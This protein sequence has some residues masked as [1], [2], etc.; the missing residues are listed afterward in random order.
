MKKERRRKEKTFIRLHSI[1]RRQSVCCCSGFLSLFLIYFKLS[2]IGCTR[3]EI[4]FPSASQIINPQESESPC[5]IMITRAPDHGC[6]RE[7]G[8][9]LVHALERLPFTRRERKRDPAIMLSCR[10]HLEW[11]Y[12]ETNEAAM[13][14]SVW[15]AVWTPLSPSRFLVPVWRSK[16]SAFFCSRFVVGRASRRLLPLRSV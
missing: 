12:R 11:K 13:H 3:K 10:F 4:R 6:R 9:R 16:F 5:C 1:E 15:S 8:C 7:S 14:P 2:G